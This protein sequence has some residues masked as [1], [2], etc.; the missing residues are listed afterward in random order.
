MNQAAETIH[1]SY[2]TVKMPDGTD[3]LVE[4][5]S[6]GSWAFVDD[7]LKQQKEFEARFADTTTIPSDWKPAT[8]IQQLIKSQKISTKDHLKAHLIEVLGCPTDIIQNGLDPAKKAYL[9]KMTA[10]KAT[11]LIIIKSINDPQWNE[12]AHAI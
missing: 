4:K 8:E 2:A 5:L 3:K 12:A 11:L 10:E 1:G 9:N 7:R 6:D